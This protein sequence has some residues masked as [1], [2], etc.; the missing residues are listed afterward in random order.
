MELHVNCK[1]PIGMSSVLEN[2]K[3]EEKIPSKD[4]RIG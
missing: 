3:F 2:S 1:I 4:E